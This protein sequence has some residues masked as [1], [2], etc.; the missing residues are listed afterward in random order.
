MLTNLK[1]KVRRNRHKIAEYSMYA[2]IVAVYVGIVALAIKAGKAAEEAAAERQQMLVDAIGRGDT[3][4]PNSDGSFWILP[5][6][7]N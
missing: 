5:N 1:A 7:R 6:N 2:G 3:I 4:L